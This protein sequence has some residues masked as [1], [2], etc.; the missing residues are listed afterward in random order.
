M[1]DKMAVDRMTA[2]HTAIKSVRRGGTVSVSGVYGGEIDPMPMMEMFDRG[3]QMRMGQCHV[4]RWKDDLLPVVTADGD[5]LGLESLASHHVPLD[6]APE[7]YETFQ[8]KKDGC[9]KVVINPSSLP[10]GSSC[11]SSQSATGRCRSTP[12]S[13][14]DCSSTSVSPRRPDPPRGGRCGS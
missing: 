3:I 14:R 5:P 2:L 8:K 13:A 10:I 4:H 11:C 7:M 9:F 6:Q 12:W 1:A